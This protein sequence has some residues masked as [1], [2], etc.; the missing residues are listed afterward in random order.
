MS[1]Y[2]A[3]T[4]NP[5]TGKYEAATWLDNHFGSHKY[6]V[7]FADGTVYNPDLIDLPTREMRKIDSKIAHLRIK[8]LEDHFRKEDDVMED[9]D[10][11][12]ICADSTWIDAQTKCD[13]KVYLPGELRL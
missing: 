13:V 3:I 1:K 4:K 7:K 2:N 9:K 6:G 10:G 8:W 12:F 5:R 11:E